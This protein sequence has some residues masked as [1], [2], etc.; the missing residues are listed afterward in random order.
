MT[1]HPKRDEIIND[2]CLSGLKQIEIAKK[3][4]VSGSYISQIRTK[5]R[6]LK[7]KPKIKEGRV[8]CFK[9]EKNDKGLIFH[10]IRNTGEFISLI[11]H[12]CNNKL[13]Q[14]E[15][16]NNDREKVVFFKTNGE[17]WDKLERLDREKA[18]NMFLRALD[19]G[20]FPQIE[21]AFTL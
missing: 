6:K 4:V 15:L 21:E 18:I 5:L 9:C 14:N 16:D 2:L 3:F 13:E 11:C 10:H 12:P 7:Y 17:L 8:V 1:T 19:R 20:D